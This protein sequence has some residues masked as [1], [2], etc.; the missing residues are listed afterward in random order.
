[1]IDAKCKGL[2]EKVAFEKQETKEKIELLRNDSSRNAEALGQLKATLEQ[3]VKLIVTQI[4]TNDNERGVGEDSLRQ[5]IVNL[6]DMLVRV[7]RSFVI[8]DDNC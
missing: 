4:K 1:M 3:Q 5:M 8:G 2:S 6:Q 7:S